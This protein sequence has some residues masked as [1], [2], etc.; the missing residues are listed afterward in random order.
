MW[1][2]LLSPC[3]VLSRLLHHCRFGF[4]ELAALSS[5]L[6]LELLGCCLPGL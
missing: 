5:R 2:M 6:L 1:L 4:L 3:R